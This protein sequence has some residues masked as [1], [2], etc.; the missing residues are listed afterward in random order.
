ML[1][2]PAP[3]SAVDEIMVTEQLDIDVKAPSIEEII[4][5]L[6]RVRNGKA[7]GID[8]IQAEVLKVH[9]GTASVL[10]HVFNKI[11]NKEVIPVDWQR[12][13]IVKLPKK[14]NLEVCDNWRGVTLLSV[15]G[16]V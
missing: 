16:K 13:V 11:W 3:Q 9:M 4:R 14:G 12:I 7:P 2:V 5:R 6:K 15:P 10:H 8:N 1:N